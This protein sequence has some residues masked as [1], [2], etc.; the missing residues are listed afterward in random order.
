MSACNSK[1]EA[2]R[3]GGAALV[4]LYCLIR[5]SDESKPLPAIRDALIE[6]AAD[7]QVALQLMRIF[8]LGP[9]LGA[10]FND[11]ESAA[12]VTLL[13]AEITLPLAENIGRETGLSLRQ[14]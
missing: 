3:K 2:L 14:P 9:T 13:Q 5:G 10:T 1:E 6:L 11:I 4:M 7:H 12:K 8:A